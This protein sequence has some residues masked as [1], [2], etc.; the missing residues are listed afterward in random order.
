MADRRSFLKGLLIAVGGG[1]YATAIVVPVKRFLLAPKKER[2]APPPAQAPVAAKAP[3]PAPAATGDQV[4]LDGADQL[5]PGSSR[6]F[7]LGDEDAILM[8]HDD[9][10]FASFSAICTHKGCTVKYDKKR[11]II[12]CPCHGGQFDPRTGANIGGPPPS[13]LDRFVVEV[14]PGKVRVKR[15]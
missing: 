12:R 10:T 5:T 2:P 14:L 3:E 15:S 7:T 4:D 6:A 8:R 1:L 9:G 13:P 11:G